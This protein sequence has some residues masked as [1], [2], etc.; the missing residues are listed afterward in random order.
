MREAGKLGVPVHLVAGNTGAGIYKQQWQQLTRSV[1]LVIRHVPELQQLSVIRHTNGSTHSS[2]KGGTS[3][4]SSGIALQANKQGHHSL[5]HGTA[6]ATAAGGVPPPHILAGAGVTITQLI[7]LLK[8]LAAAES[9]AGQQQ[10]AQNLS[11]LVQHLSRAAGTL[12]RNAATLGG[13]LMLIKTQ[14][15]ES[16]LLPYMLAAGKAVRLAGDSGAAELCGDQANT[17]GSTHEGSKASEVFNKYLL[18]CCGMQVLNLNA[19][20]CTG[21]LSG[22]LLRVS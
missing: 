22:Y 19:L 14:H 18:W 9:A 12:V 4:E 3:A 21:N 2:S 1:N 13:H 20:M 17:V 8:N 5:Q 10:N 7:T 6:A 15:L 11:F 16:D